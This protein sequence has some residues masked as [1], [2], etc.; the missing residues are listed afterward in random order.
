MVHLAFAG[1]ERIYDCRSFAQ[2]NDMG[3]C[4]RFAD[5]LLG[6]GV[7]HIPRGMWYLSA[8]HTDGDIEAA[9]EAAEMALPKLDQA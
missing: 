5:L 4:R 3:R 8:A 6:Q 9:L 1:P 2:N 7:R